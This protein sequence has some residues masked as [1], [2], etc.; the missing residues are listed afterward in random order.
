MLFRYADDNEK[1][2]SSGGAVADPLTLSCSVS[3]QLSQLAK[4]SLTS[5][6]V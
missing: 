1:F 6:L 2:M 4:L 5:G 3:T